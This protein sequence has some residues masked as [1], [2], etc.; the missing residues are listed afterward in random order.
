[1]RQPTLFY[2]FGFLLL[3]G[4]VGGANQVTISAQGGQMPTAVHEMKTD[5]GSMMF[6]DM[7]DMTLYTFAKDTPGTSNCNDQC[8]KNWPPVMA[9]ADAKVMGDWT[10]V[11]RS[12][13]THQWAY[14]GMPLYTWAKDQK[15]GDKTG[16]GMAN[17]AWKVAMMKP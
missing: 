6:T 8:A 17:G 13:G 9:P 12:D 16:D 5:S 3:A 15:P 11:T 14:K 7:H 4:F 10:V 1:M 2:G